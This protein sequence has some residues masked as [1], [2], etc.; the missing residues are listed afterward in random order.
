MLK[1]I[2]IEEKNRVYHTN[3]KIVNEI[4]NEILSI[5]DTILKFYCSD[6]E[7]CDSIYRNKYWIFKKDGTYF[8]KN[9]I[10]KDKNKI[11]INKSQPITNVNE[12]FDFI[13][14]NRLDTINSEPETEWW[15]DHCGGISIKYIISNDTLIDTYLEHMQITKGDSLHLKNK[16]AKKLIKYLKANKKT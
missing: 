7:L 14:T 8:L 13:H 5:S 9:T 2:Y 3:E 1:I 4:D 15:C 6:Y 10:Y 11:S 12:L 16:L